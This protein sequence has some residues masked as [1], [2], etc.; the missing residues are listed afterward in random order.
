MVGSVFHWTQW[1][2]GSATVGWQIDS[3]SRQHVQLGH[4]HMCIPYCMQ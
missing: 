2:L 3:S 4:M 1:V